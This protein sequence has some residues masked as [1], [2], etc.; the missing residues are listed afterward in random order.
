VLAVACPKCRNK[1]EL[2]IAS[3]GL[4]T[5]GEGSRHQFHRSAFLPDCHRMPSLVRLQS[6]VAH[7]PKGSPAIREIILIGPCA[8]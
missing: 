3:R 7:A 6:W 4:A 2:R 8:Y 1:K 5:A